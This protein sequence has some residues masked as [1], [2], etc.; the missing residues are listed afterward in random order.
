MPPGPDI[1]GE[2]YCA[3]LPKVSLGGHSRSLPKAPILLLWRL[4]LKKK[5]KKTRL[6]VDEGWGR[7]VNSRTF[8]FNV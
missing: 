4:I 2:A 8:H 5:K 6:G 1:D 3:A 7:H